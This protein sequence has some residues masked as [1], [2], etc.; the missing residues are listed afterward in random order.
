[1]DNENIFRWDFFLKKEKNI[2]SN[3]SWY[4]SSTSLMC[5]ALRTHGIGKVMLTSI[6]ILVSF[7][8]LNYCPEHEG[9]SSH[10]FDVFYLSNL[11]G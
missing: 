1:M 6:G 10:V 9:R 4:K 7:M 8:R 5:K 2:K 3:A 11:L